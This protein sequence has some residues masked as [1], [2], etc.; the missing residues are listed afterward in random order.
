MPVAAAAVLLVLQP[1]ELGGLEAEETEQ[2]LRTVLLGRLIPVAV[3]VAVVKS[4][5]RFTV[6]ALAEMVS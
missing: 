1:E 2:A 6:G 3:V 4:H 5:R